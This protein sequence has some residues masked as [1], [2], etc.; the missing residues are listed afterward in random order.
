MEKF[1]KRIIDSVPPPISEP[2]NHNKL[3][4]KNVFIYLFFSLIKKF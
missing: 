4:L 3:F 2:L 1:Q